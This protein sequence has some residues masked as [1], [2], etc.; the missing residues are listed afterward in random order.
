[1][2]FVV[3]STS[4]IPSL[5]HSTSPFRTPNSSCKCA[6]HFSTHERSSNRKTPSST[7]NLKSQLE[8]PF[9]YTPKHK[10]QNE[11]PYSDTM[12]A[13]FQVEI[14]FLHRKKVISQKKISYFRIGR[15][16]ERELT[17]YLLTPKM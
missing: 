12:K 8:K 3:L 1:M 5:Q 10:F 17:N 4:S 15:K 7:P 13:K 14:S 11:I 6:E 2:S 16:S 9:P